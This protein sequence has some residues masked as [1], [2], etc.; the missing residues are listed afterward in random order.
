[1]ASQLDKTQGHIDSLLDKEKLKYHEAIEIQ[2]GLRRELVAA[3]EALREAH[4]VSDGCRKTMEILDMNLNQE[5]LESAGARATIDKIEKTLQSLQVKSAASERGDS[6]STGCQTAPPDASSDTSQPATKS[7]AIA[8]DTGIFEDLQKALKKAEG[9]RDDYRQLLAAS[10][11]R[12]KTKSES[13]AARVREAQVA[14]SK[15]TSVL[16][17]ARLERK[18]ALGARDKAV[19]EAKAVKKDCEEAQR[20]RAAMGHALKDARTEIETLSAKVE[21]ATVGKGEAERTAEEAQEAMKVLIEDLARARREVED[22]VQ[23]VRRSQDEVIQMKEARRRQAEASQA[24]HRT[25]EAL[26]AAQVEIGRLAEKLQMAEKA[27]VDSERAAKSAQEGCRAAA[28]SLEKTFADFSVAQADIKTLN[29]Q[30]QTSKAELD[31]CETTVRD[32]Q[33]VCVDRERALKKIQLDELEAAQS[34]ISNLSA[35]MKEIILEN[36]SLEE[37]RDRAVI[38]EKDAQL[39]KNAITERIKEMNAELDE[40]AKRIQTAED[41]MTAAQS[42]RRDAN[43]TIATLQQAKGEADIERREALAEHAKAVKRATRAE[44]NRDEAVA[45]AD[46]QTEKVRAAWKERESMVK[47]IQGLKDNFHIQRQ[48]TRTTIASWDEEAVKAKSR[49][50]KLTNVRKEVA[51]LKQQLRIVTGVKGEPSADRRP[52]DGGAG[53]RKPRNSGI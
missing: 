35:D 13:L 44:K 28:T 8:T 33:T 18:S 41:A 51:S 27:H 12:E 52:V 2:Q 36:R 45:K 32:L 40:H 5:R 43:D 22:L 1:M 30:V 24:E 9:E 16:Q 20:E 47:R 26:V 21:A 14:T 53:D 23:A 39:A 37:A 42:D 7:N 6:V 38:A 50:K 29:A 15:V 25:S 34:T 46:A 19:D 11:A 48:E 3:Q 10:E 31:R 4:K 49:L 17:E